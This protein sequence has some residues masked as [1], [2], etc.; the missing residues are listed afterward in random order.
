M[1]AL[2]PHGASP[3]R[4]GLRAAQVAAPR[5]RAAQG[6]GLEVQASSNEPVFHLTEAAALH[7]KRLNAEQPDTATFR[8]ATLPTTGPQGTT[9]LVAGATGCVLL[10]PE[11]VPFMLSP[12][13]P[14]PLCLM[15]T[16]ARTQHP[17]N[18][19]QRTYA[20]APTGSGS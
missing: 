16:R 7:L 14:S 19:R 18:S 2:R 13:D 1:L 10:C 17:N 12:R 20:G 6:R 3:G 15:C 5:R 9:V 4:Q 11:A 8:F